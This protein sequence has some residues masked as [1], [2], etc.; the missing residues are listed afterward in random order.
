M[1]EEKK[2]RKKVSTLRLDNS[3]YSTVNIDLRSRIV[4][5]SSCTSV[6]IRYKCNSG[7]LEIALYLCTLHFTGWGQSVQIRKFYEKKSSSHPPAGLASLAVGGLS[8]ALCALANNILFP[9]LAPQSI[10]IDI[11]LRKSFG[12]K[13]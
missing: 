5:A 8:P 11:S 12:A 6:F 3:I 13:F 4:R 9:L 10:S 2:S 1:R 7:T